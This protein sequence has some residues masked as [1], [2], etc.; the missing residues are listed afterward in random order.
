MPV[1]I[2]S[3]TAV[4]D[5]EVVERLVT[6]NLPLVGYLVNELAVRL[7]GHVCRDDLT[8]AGMTALLQAARAYDSDRGVPF[9]RYASTRIRGAM[10]DELR[11]QD[12]AGRSVRQKAR[13]RD[14]AATQL[15]ATLGRPATRDELAAYMGVDPSA[16]SS[17]DRDVHRSVVLSLARA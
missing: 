2:A 3:T 6:E 16:L 14:N 12:W 17:T 4:P 7:P 1:T 9:S 13:E 11:A 8:S 15:E 10:L 5:A